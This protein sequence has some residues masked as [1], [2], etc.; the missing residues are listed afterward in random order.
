MIVA[1]DARILVV[2]ARGAQLGSLDFER[3]EHLLE[4]AV[5][6]GGRVVLPMPVIAEFLVRTDEATAAWLSGLERKRGVLA[7]PFDRRA[8][9]DCALLDAAAINKGDKRG[10][11]KEPWQRIKVDRQIVAIA[12]SVGASLIV[13]NDAGLSTTAQAAG[14]EARR[15]EDLDL[16][17][18]ARQGRLPFDP[19]AAAT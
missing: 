16:P 17:A 12:K 11:R 14:I 5:G 1:L 10:G 4:V 8:A 6:A 9:V 19:G 3:L 15:L 7:A 18:S 2:W 13:T